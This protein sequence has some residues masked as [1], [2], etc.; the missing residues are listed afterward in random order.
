[1]TFACLGGWELKGLVI[2]CVRRRR[3]NGLARGVSRNIRSFGVYSVYLRVA[4]LNGKPPVCLTK[5]GGRGGGQL[6]NL[7]SR[8]DKTIATPHPG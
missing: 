4:S 3:I 1:M 5:G 2:R 7:P 6:K 8:K